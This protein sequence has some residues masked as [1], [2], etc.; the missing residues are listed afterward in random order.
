MLL[1]LFFFWVYSKWMS[2][3]VK[4]HFIQVEY[5]VSPNSQTNVR[6]SVEL[7]TY[8]NSD[9]D[10]ISESNTMPIYNNHYSFTFDGI[11]NAAIP[12]KPEY[13]ESLSDIIGPILYKELD[14]TCK[15]HNLNINSF[16]EL[17]YVRHFD[18]EKQSSVLKH[19]IS[20]ST[21]QWWK[22]LNITGINDFTLSNYLRDSILRIIPNSFNERINKNSLLM[23]G[24]RNITESFILTDF[25]GYP[26]GATIIM[27]LRIGTHLDNNVCDKLSLF[28]K[29]W[30][31]MED[32]TKSYYIIDLYTHSITDMSLKMSFSGTVD[33]KPDISIIDKMYK[34]SPYYDNSC[35]Y[36]DSI[37]QSDK[38]TIRK[39]YFNFN[40]NRNIFEERERDIFHS[41]SEVIRKDYIEEDTRYYFERNSLIIRAN[42]NTIIPDHNT[43]MKCLV[44]FNDMEN[45]QTMR[46]FI[47][48][49]FITLTL[50]T[51]IKSLWKI[52]K[53]FSKA[54]N[55]IWK[56]T[57]TETTK[58]WLTLSKMKTMRSRKKQA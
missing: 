15:N 13:Y 48:A 46:L 51:M 44:K 5:L 22:S 1:F 53:T 36:S 23:R 17:F 25:E 8:K 32:I 24:Y 43:R 9:I 57:V 54:T 31:Q 33:C 6:A 40:S 38:E 7:T 39:D 27:P 20:M 11:D 28:L 4:R 14:D 52:R 42:Y 19:D 12:R 34:H 26:S 55:S 37:F 2:I 29:K 45:I 3:P 49:A 35:F 41:E 16:R 10:L 56:Q 30:I 47:L 58:L 50:T 18:N 21:A